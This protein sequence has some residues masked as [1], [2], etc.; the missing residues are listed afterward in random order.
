MFVVEGIL[1]FSVG[2]NGE[3]GLRELQRVL[4]GTHG[5]AYANEGVYASRVCLAS[6]C[7][8]IQ[9][10]LLVFRTNR[11]AVISVGEYV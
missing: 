4:N 2:C 7:I 3:E 1:G 8:A 10:E 9:M 5:Y 11:F 6:W